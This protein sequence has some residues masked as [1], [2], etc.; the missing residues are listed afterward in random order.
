VLAKVAGGLNRSSGAMGV[1]GPSAGPSGGASALDPASLDGLD[2]G[3]ETMEHE[4]HPGF[5]VIEPERL[6]VWAWVEAAEGSVTGAIDRARQAAALAAEHRQWGYE[7]NALAAA[8][9][10]GDAA[11]SGR[12]TE[13]SRFVD[14]PRVAAA[15]AQAAALAVAD[16]KG[17]VEASRRFEDMGDLLSAADAAAQA[18]QCFSDADRVAY[19]EASARVRRLHAACEGAMTPALAAALHPLPLTEREREIVSLAAN[20]LSNR[21]IADRLVVSIRTV[22]GHLYRAGAKLGTSDRGRFAGLL[23]GN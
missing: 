19:L 5:A 7:A 12:L 2:P 16:G 15:A 9:R 4:R 1:P 13:L 18:A 8:V 3:P 6:L 17:L 14:G 22:E 21:E 20:G 11:S 10:F 23:H